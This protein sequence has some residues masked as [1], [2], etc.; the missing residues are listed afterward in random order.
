ML[1]LVIIHN[2]SLKTVAR[3]RRQIL[4][5]LGGLEPVQF[6]PG[7]PFNARQR[8]DSLSGGE[9]SRSPVSVADDR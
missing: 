7:W 3:Q 1:S 4:Q 9:I 6:E 2:Q 5:R 8:L